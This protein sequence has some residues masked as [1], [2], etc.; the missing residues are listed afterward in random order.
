MTLRSVCVREGGTGLLAESQTKVVSVCK[1][2]GNR[3]FCA[4]SKATVPTGNPGTLHLLNL[5]S[6]L[7]TTYP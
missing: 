5:T 1:A 3:Q 6:A 2:L 7:C 4:Q